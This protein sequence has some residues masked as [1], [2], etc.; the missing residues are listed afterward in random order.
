MALSNDIIS[1]FVELTKTS[2]KIQNEA[3]VYGTIVTDG[4]NTY[5]KLDGSEQLTPIETTT[6]VAGGERVIV[7][8]KDHKATV[9]GNITSPSVNNGQLEDV[10]DQISEFEVVIADR[11]TANEIVVGR[12]EADNVIINK[13][14]TAIEGEFETIKADNIT[15]NE[16][17]TANK[18]AIADLD[19]K[20]LSAETAD[21]KYATIGGLNAANAEINDL[22]ANHAEFS[23]A[24][25]KR[26]E[27]DE[28]SIKKLDAEKLSAKDADIK[29]ANIDF[30][31]INMAAVEKLFAESG[32]IKDL[33]VGDTS[34]TGELVG[35][36]IKGDLIEANTLVADKLVIKGS[37]GLYYKLNTDGMTTEA[38]QT[39]YNSLNG[40]II[41]AKSITAS[42]INVKDLVAF[43]ATIGGF[44][45]SS[46][47]IYS[48]VKTSVDNTTN[49]I[50]LD[51]D[52]QVAFGD[53]NNYLKFFRD[54][55][56]AWKLMISAN[57]L[58]FS[59]SD[60]TVE[61]VID[62]IDSKVQK[63]VKT[64][65]DY[66]ASS[67]S[68]TTKP[69]TGWQTTPPVWVNGMFIWA[70]TKTTYTDGS[71]QE[72]DP[73]CITGAKGENGKPGIDG[74]SGK[75]VK[76]VTNYYLAIGKNTGVVESTSGWTTTIQTIT[77]TNKYL[78]N[79]E[80][81][82]YTDNSTTKTTPVIIGVYG[83]KGQTG[84]NGQNGSDGNGIQSITEKYAVSTSN[85]TAP[86][87]WY[88]AVQ[89]MSQTNKYLW[90]YE[91]IRYTNGTTSE[92]KK[93]VIGVYG[94][95][96]NTGATGPSGVGIQSVDVEYYLSTS[97][98]T[99]SGGS[100][101]TTAPTW[102]NGKYMWS[103][104]KTVTTNGQTK[105]SNAACITG[106]KGSTGS[107]GATGST[108]QGIESITEEYY[109]STSKTTQSGG[110]WTTTPPIWSS[111]KYLWTRSKIVYKNP[112]ETAYTK[113]VCDN[114]WEAVNEV[115]IGGRNLW[116]NS[117]FNQ[118]LDSYSLTLSEGTITLDNKKFN[119]NNAV[120]F[121]RVGSVF[122]DSRCYIT[123][124]QSPT[125]SSFKKGD[126]FILT[127]WVY[128]ERQLDGVDISSIMVR[129]SSGD[130]P[131][132]YIPTTADVVGK[133]IKLTSNVFKAGQDG[134]FSNC[135]VLLGGNGKFK[136]S[137]IQLEKGNK[138][139]DWTPAPEDVEAN[140]DN[141]KIGGRNLLINSGDLYLFG[142][143]YPSSSKREKGKITVVTNGRFNSYAWI[144]S[145]TD[146][147]T[148]YLSKSIKDLSTPIGKEVTFSI[149]IKTI[150][151]TKSG[152]TVSIDYRNETSVIDR[153]EID[154]EPN[155]NNQWIRY[156]SKIKSTR[157]DNIKSLFS[158]RTVDDT[159]DLTGVVIEYRNCMIEEGNK[160]T[161]WTPA[162][163]DIKANIDN[164][165]ATMNGAFKDGILSDAE[166]KAIKQSLN[167]IKGDAEEVQKQYDTVYNNSNLIGTP[168]SNLLTAKTSYN[169]A[170]NSLISFINTALSASTVTDSMIISIDSAFGTYR[171]A[172]GTFNTR[173][174]EAID[175]INS[176]KVD[177]IKIG[178]ENLIFR[179]KYWQTTTPTVVQLTAEPEHSRIRIKKVTADEAKH[180]YLNFVKT[181]TKGKTYTLSYDIYTDM[182]ITSE[183]LLFLRCNGNGQALQYM[184]DQT[185]SSINTW[186]HKEL[187]FVCNHSGTDDISIDSL[188]L[189]T[190]HF[191][192]GQTIL[193]R[194]IKMEEGNKATTYSYAPE[195]ER[196][197]AS[198]AGVN[199]LPNTKSLIVTGVTGVNYKYESR[200][201]V[202]AINLKPFTIYTVS[203]KCKVLSGNTT[204][205]SIGV[206]N[207]KID[208]VYQRGDLV[209]TNDRMSWTFYTRNATNCSKLLF[210]AGLAGQTGTN[211][212]EYSEI[213]LE[214]TSIAS[215]KWIPNAG[216]VDYVIESKKV[217][218][219]NL[220]LNTKNMKDT[221]GW[222]GNI[223]VTRSG[224]L[225]EPVFYNITTTTSEAVSG[226]SRF[227]VKPNTKYCFSMLLNINYS[228]KSVDAW[229][230]GRF[231]DSTNEYDNPIRFITEWQEVRNVYTRVV[232]TFTTGPNDYDGFIR[233]DNNCKTADATGDSV[234][235]WTEAMVAEGD[236]FAGYSPSIE[237]MNLRVTKAE[238]DL[239]V[240][241]NAISAKVWGED[242][243]VALGRQAD[244]L[245]RNGNGGTK[246][247]SNFSQW[248]F[249]GNVRGSKDYPSFQTQP[250]KVNP[251]RIDD[252]IYI[253]KSKDYRL[254]Y[255]L[256]ATSEDSVNKVYF[257]VSCFDIDGNAINI[258][259]ISFIPKTTTKL[260]RELKN[261]D[262]T[263]EV[264]SLENWLTSSSVVNYQRTIIS[265]NYRDSTGYQYP[266][267]T[268]SKNNGKKYGYALWN[269]ITDEDKS[270]GI[271][272]LTKPW[273]GDT[274]AIGTH[275]SQNNSGSTYLYVGAKGIVS[276]SDRWIPY[277]EVIPGSS[278]RHGTAYIKLGILGAQSVYLSNLYFGID[279]AT[280]GQINDLSNTVTNVQKTVSQHTVDLSGITSKVEKIESSDFQVHNLQ[281]HSGGKYKDAGIE[282]WSMYGKDTLSWFTNYGSPGTFE[283]YYD[284]YK[285]GSSGGI[286]AYSQSPIP[287]TAGEKYTVSF[288][289]GRSAVGGATHRFVIQCSNTYPFGSVTQNA[290]D[291]YMPSTQANTIIRQEFQ[292]TIPDGV[293]SIKVALVNSVSGEGQSCS[294][295]IDK[296]MINKG[297]V[298]YDWS[299]H[300]YDIESQFKSVEQKITAESILTTISSG[301]NGNKG[302][303]NTMQFLLDKDGATIKNGALTILNNAGEQVLKGD[304]DGNLIMHGVFTTYDN[305]RKSIEINGSRL[306]LFNR[307]DASNKESGWIVPSINDDGETSISIGHNE[308]SAFA[309]RYTYGTQEYN[310]YSYM[311][312][313]YYNVYGRP[314]DQTKYTIS[315]NEPMMLWYE[316]MMCDIFKF[317]S[318]KY[319]AHIK[320]YDSGLYGN[321][322]VVG[323][324]G[325]GRVTSY[326]NTYAD[327][328]MLGR[329]G[330]NPNP[331][332]YTSLGQYSADSDTSYYRSL[333][334]SSSGV[335]VKGN[336]SVSG[337][338][339][340]LVNTKNYGRINL[341]AYETTDSY[342]G[343]IGQGILDE[344]GLCYI[345]I[346]TIFLET[347]NTKNDYQVFLQKYGPGDIWVESKTE[348]YFVVKGA[349][350]TTFAWELKAKQLG[351]ETTRLEQS[352]ND[353]IPEIS[354][355]VDCDDREINELNKV[356]KGGI[357]KYE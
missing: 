89:A 188:A 153:A 113:P 262:T 221:S 225:N 127:A 337:T 232:G 159:L 171:T 330:S 173:L 214:E 94:D 34:I 130:N 299:P 223:G 318:Y 109:L 219:N 193:F 356:L 46:N 319:G 202:T 67:S 7:R 237:D 230:I 263:I 250:T 252:R 231:K 131:R 148:T 146:K 141:I 151:L 295:Y 216:D 249:V 327:V 77:P 265:W 349:P 51:K 116:P 243:N 301:I 57:S 132:I 275:I 176:K 144:Y 143:D 62:D 184:K 273:S 294:F 355:N 135:Y 339:N 345:S 326:G 357:L 99:L 316:T 260:K 302:S 181:L 261:G 198:R 309:I 85:T 282:A 328:H 55:D 247:N 183:R 293:K 145:E 64:V 9:T 292:F 121:D 320:F 174:Q 79:Y 95:K 343:D 163:E 283:D 142:S 59:T 354:Y 233:I 21:L 285:G 297:L 239:T 47:S 256:K 335:E 136:V 289:Y 334:V 97:S 18:A 264:E 87:T 229:W 128:I 58:K 154:I 246:D 226:T 75:G 182:P 317:D 248:T 81:V 287:V 134:T 10:K 274:L 311:S 281:R 72:S 197:E 156:S 348:T 251:A 160:A 244:N 111:G 185:V 155:K 52:G 192:E 103:R 207:S 206:T 102:Q 65:I 28:A 38:E 44:N 33:V 161:D 331:N 227:R 39:E 195:D 74:A 83:D 306:S 56:G 346:D 276:F 86:T 91:I 61:E 284:L 5:V 107:T 201:I 129:G 50:Y 199:M 104:T 305:D 240:V 191:N 69:T 164:L 210:Y 180:T 258:Q 71:S 133:W 288:N 259:D 270:A 300:E 307:W 238:S 167:I 26:L 205:C 149:D 42:K 2:D 125:I 76:T 118:G 19:A 158:I 27:A 224:V 22:K 323:A 122:G 115:E 96:G 208:V 1:Q 308:G 291:R 45:I 279:R 100:W 313:D 11:V 235:Y 271:I 17:L 162:P 333:I 105:Y 92:T 290:V 310:M 32:I 286:Y 60:K 172:L 324:V 73:V 124:K 351:Y 49:G 303:I 190:S 157:T 350:N 338:K 211:K 277:D 213:M 152:V 8:I 329:R 41:T 217:A 280:S 234:I 12:I 48:G 24:T 187:T 36:T 98:T 178:G 37:D 266:K 341:N 278:F 325:C 272:R 336:F 168:K 166:K 138:P 139:T 3:S 321:D 108:G 117:S 106:S 194:N 30:A 347:I 20:K 93:R 322:G 177:N 340:R 101:S 312:F 222:T 200:Q 13:K 268:Y 314:S 150:G 253:D 68:P 215:E 126:E 15:I 82:T 196:L 242:I 25:I 315:V 6:N 169:S 269:S 236:V 228:C 344:N 4:N 53:S 123:T 165:E 140:I 245:I 66:Y 241:N 212:L 88:D 29:Y 23:E 296:I 43:G 220:I 120:V 204:K 78:W 352:K 254:S 298:A 70:K 63:T 203:F 119:G 175:S 267:E 35:V 186:I 218:I 80:V 353:Y 342:F 147:P 257:I 170:Y 16:K 114:S 110:S 54:T 304:S 332:S 112:T 255:E 209:I 84:A 137:Q 40:S 90:N 31:N 189:S 179:E 14:L